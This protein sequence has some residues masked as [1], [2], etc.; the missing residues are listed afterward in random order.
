MRFFWQKL[1]RSYGWLAARAVIASKLIET[2]FSQMTSHRI[3]LVSAITLF[4]GIFVVFYFVGL[5]G[6]SKPPILP[7]EI[8]LAGPWRL[9]LQDDPRFSTKD[10]ED[11]SWCFSGV[12][13]PALGRANPKNPNCTEGYYPADEMRGNTYWYRTWV[14]IP[15]GAGWK[16]PSL[17]LG[18]IKHK[19]WIYWNEE[20]IEISNFKDGTG[21]TT[22]QLEESKVTPG[23]HLLAIRVS[24]LNTRYPGIFHAYPR[25]IALG[26]TDGNIAQ[27][28][29]IIKQRYVVPAIVLFIQSAGLLLTVLLLAL[30]K[31]SGAQ[32]FWLAIYFFGTAVVAAEKI[33]PSEL[34]NLI[35]RISVATTSFGVFGYSLR[36]HNWI[37]IQLNIVSRALFF[38]MIVTIVTYFYFFS[39]GA[40][41][42]KTAT[43]ITLAI[44]IVPFL[45]FGISLFYWIIS[46]FKNDRSH[47]SLLAFTSLLILGSLH[48]VNVAN[49][50]FFFAT[51]I[52]TDHP[53]FKMALSVALIAVMIYQYTQQ[54]RTLAFFGRF[55]RPGLK[56]LLEEKV[57][58]ATYT[59]G[60]FFRPRQIA[61]LK[62]DIVGHTETTF[63]MPYG[64]KRLF[65]DTW[66]TVI[67]QV[68]AHRVFM[69]KNVG[70]GSIYCFSE[71]HK[72]GSCVSALNA[73]LE[74]RDQAVQRF[75]REFLNRLE[76]FLAITDELKEPAE[77]FFRSY[78]ARTGVDFR[79][80]R[81]KVQH[82]PGLWLSWMR[83][84]GA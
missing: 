83:A 79:S 70:D 17:F 1:L 19:A 75:D 80:R 38:L 41:S 45:A 49:E 51:P 59:D 67:D 26:E 54:E 84:S 58:K 56:K 43:L 25:K 46:S 30:G 11:S 27:H 69:D 40:L 2:P 71:H 52:V 31:G 72:E 28:N 62:I 76:Q 5:I 23:R 68:V 24:S 10:Y 18:A 44:A 39:L 55:V 35:V 48:A 37:G 74:I 47:S 81:T 22:V 57:S 33:S 65:Q 21:M 12:P 53:V 16:E 34:K 60:K 3:N 42:G 14:E 13:S 9:S 77:A 8:D 32:F 64:I 7:G 61:I 15:E 6:P 63:Q 66:F 73:A 78:Q 50:F 29:T 82:C 4:T 20:L 36:F